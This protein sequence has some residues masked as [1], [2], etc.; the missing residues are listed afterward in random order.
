M[1]ILFY[2]K[3]T[4][5]FR[6]RRWQILESNFRGQRVETTSTV[7]ELARRLREP[8]EGDQ[9]VILLISDREELERI[10]SL[11]DLFLNIPLIIQV[12]DGSVE[13]LH[14]AHRLRPRFLDTGQD[15]FQ[16]VL[17]VL[18]KMLN[19]PLPTLPALP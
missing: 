1:R 3:E 10:L 5:D 6:N 2:S 9:I 14:M 16:S 18:R 19:R 8:S 7:D 4:D 15:A 12:P 17:E 13:T 11:Q